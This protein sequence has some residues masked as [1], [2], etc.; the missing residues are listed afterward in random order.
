MNGPSDAIAQDPPVGLDHLYRTVVEHAT[1]GIAVIQDGR[2]VFAN[3]SVA[4]IGGMTVDELVGRSIAD[5]FHPDDLPQAEARQA[6]RMRGETGGYRAELRVLQPTG[7]VRWVRVGVAGCDWNGRPAS[8]GLVTDV[9]ARREAEL[10]LRSTLQERETILQNALV[11]ISLAVERRHVWVNRR[12]EELLGYG[13]GELVGASSQVHFASVDAWRAFGEEAYPQLARGQGYRGEIQMRRKEGSLAWVEVY[14][15]AIDPPDLSRGTIWTYLDISERR[16]AEG[17]TR[18][19]LDKQRQLNELKARFVS[20]ASHEFRTPLAAIYSSA[21]LLRRYG[22]RLPATERREILD[23]I[24]AGVHRMTRLLDDVLLFGRADAGRLEFA[25]RRLDLRALCAGLVEDLRRG[26]G[27]AAQDVE[28]DWQAGAESACLD[29][30]LLRHVLGNLLSNAVKY[31]PDGG[32]VRL[33]V[34][35][36]SEALCFE[37]TDQ[38]IGIPPDDLPR[39]FDVF[40]RGSNVGAIDGTGLGLAIVRL[41]V[42]RHGGRIEVGSEPGRGSRFTVTLPE[43]EP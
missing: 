21:E 33:A 4:S 7:G 34:R 29:E 15:A 27:R 22:D 40:H 10:A 26:G 13:P 11:G 1:E 18:A 12:L 25:P 31:S 38:G 6:A 23:S 28:L 42:E 17:A 14:G 36:D 39:L 8:L 9:T 19:A 32:R 41:A 30:Q 5:V 3:P 16:R 35:R 20:M 2:F 37:V 24:T 43:A